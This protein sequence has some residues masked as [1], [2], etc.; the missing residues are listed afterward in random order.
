MHNKVKKYLKSKHRFQPQ[1]GVCH[2][3]E[4][5]D[6][7]RRSFLKRLGLV[8]LGTS[9]TLGGL[10]FEAF[11]ESMMGSALNTSD[12]GDRILV[13]IRLA[14]GNDGLNSIVPFT[15][16]EYYN[17]RPSLA[18]QQNEIWKMNT[19][20]GM[21]NTMQ[22]LQ[23]MWEEGHMKVVHNV[24]Y[25]KPNYSHFRSSDIWASASDS[26]EYL[27]T[28]WLGRWLE[29]EYPTFGT[30]APSV[31]PA[32]QI[33]VESNLIFK[34][35]VGH[36]NLSI[37]NPTE[38]YQI[39]ASGSLYDVDFLAN[40]PHLDELKYLR[41]VANSSFRY[42]E[43]LQQAYG[44]SINA[45][46]YPDVGLAEQLA[47][48]A[49]LIKGSLG[50]KVYMVTIGG[51]D[52]H[53]DQLNNH[54]RLMNN[55]AESVSAFYKDLATT[56]WDDKVLSM[57][58]SEFGRTVFENGS[59]GTDHG[60]SGPMMI[61]GK[62]IGNGFVGNPIDLLDLDNYGDPKFDVDFRQ[63]YG[64]VFKDWLC[65][66]PNTVDYVLGGAFPTLDGL[67][68]G[69]EAEIGANKYQALLGHNKKSPGSNY[70]IIKYAMQWRGDM[71]LSILSTSG[72]TLRIL[73]NEFKE[74]GSYTYE[75]NPL[76]L[77]LSNGSYLYKLETGGKI[78][79][80]PLEW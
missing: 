23:N 18:L 34:A 16:D 31:P 49:R 53:S 79:V 72:Q 55:L 1:D 26:K 37:T 22:S 39:A 15:N 65:V 5:S 25:P 75:F 3:D 10:P 61:F 41:R 51:F 28:G 54:P 76:E 40:S 69:G 30:T 24:G 38:F 13:I 73:V 4:H 50:T 71:R 43:T 74:K 56:G 42:A 68:P 46:N 17:I 32:L 67:L 7:S 66:D 19:D 78:Y 2:A 29:N 60:T 80:R 77:F 64:T 57:T 45:V 11:G 6:A 47:I 70:F 52:T 27:E 14:G 62:D 8:G 36:M 58:F 21:P 44:T 35:D 48:V 12:C 63:V 59:V 9:V 33:G 20:F